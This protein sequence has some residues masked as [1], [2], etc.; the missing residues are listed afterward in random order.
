MQSLIFL[1]CIHGQCLQ[2]FITVHVG[3]EMQS[4]INRHIA[5]REGD[6]ELQLQ[7]I[8]AVDAEWMTYGRS[9]QAVYNLYTCTDADQWQW[10]QA[11]YSELCWQCILEV[12]EDFLW[13]CTETLFRRLS[14]REQKELLS[15]NLSRISGMIWSVYRRTLPENSC[16]N[17]PHVGPYTH[18]VGGPSR[19]HP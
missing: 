12:D 17:F 15:R 19:C 6:E 3:I 9:I 10:I 1:K 2:H 16:K 14:V 18:T 4:Y 13:Q 8:K 7:C 11:L 5:Y